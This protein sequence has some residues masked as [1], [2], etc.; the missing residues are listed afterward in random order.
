MGGKGRTPKPTALLTLIGS[1]RASRRKAEPR[2]L[3]GAPPRP[4]WLTGE[5]VVAWDYVVPLLLGAGV[6]TPL[7]GLT[8]ATWCTTWSR[9]RACL[10]VLERDGET[11]TA[12]TAHGT[13]RQ[14]QRP[15]AGLSIALAA[16][17]RQLGDR[18]GLTPAARTRLH[19]TVPMPTGRPR[20][21]EPG[22]GGP[23]PPAAPVSLPP[24]P[25]AAHAPA[26]LSPPTAS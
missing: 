5:A 18:L 19:S 20:P 11:Y 7:D 17:L 12:T 24:S 15:E 4:E 6:L 8:L 16:E 25:P 2:M 13:T 26:P 9:W 10:A 22:A 3:A 23:R 21:W 1:S 14:V